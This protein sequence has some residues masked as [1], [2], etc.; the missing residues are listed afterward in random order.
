M[1]GFSAFGLA[2][3]SYTSSGTNGSC[4]CSEEAWVPTAQ[5]CGGKE[6]GSLGS[7][8]KASREYTFITAGFSHFGQKKQPFKCITLRGFK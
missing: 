2:S 1:C 3:C 4:L 8:Y 7:W 6:S 5:G